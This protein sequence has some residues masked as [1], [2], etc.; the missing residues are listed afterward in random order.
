MIEKQLVLNS[1]ILN[2]SQ[3]LLNAEIQLRFGEFKKLLFGK[4][5]IQNTLISIYYHAIPTE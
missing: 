5:P 4:N 3:K 2:Y 1:I